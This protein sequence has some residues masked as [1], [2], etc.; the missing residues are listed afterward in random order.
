MNNYN[1]IKSINQELLYNLIN[2]GII[3]IHIMDYKLIYETYLKD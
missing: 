1:F 3:P 2:R